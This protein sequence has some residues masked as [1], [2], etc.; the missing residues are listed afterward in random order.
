[1]FDGAQ[2]RLWGMPL[3]FW[4]SGPL[5]A[6]FHL[7]TAVVAT[8]GAMVGSFLNVVIH[9]VPQGKSVVRP[10]SHCPGC[11]AAIPLRLNLPIFSW[12]WLRGRARCC[13]APISPRYIAIEALTAALAVASWLA[14][15]HENPGVAVAWMILWCLL[16][17]ASAVDLEHFMI[18]DRIS[19]GGAVLG[20]FLSAAIPQ[21]HGTA[22][23]SEA[24]ERSALGACVGA[25]LVYGIVRLGKLAFG[26][27]RVDLGPQ[28]R[29][30]F[31]ET[32]IRTPDS[33]LP[34][35]ELFYR[36]S[37]AVVCKA[38]RVELADRC[39]WDAD[40]RLELMREPPR[41]RIG[42]LEMDASEQPWMAVET[43]SVVFPREAMG[44][45]DVKLMAAIGAFLGWQATL[46]ALLGSSLLGSAVG[47]GLILGRRRDWGA[48]LPFG[49]YL[50]VGALVYAF[51]GR[52][53]V[54]RWLALGR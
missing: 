37:D 34:Y 44:L 18:P 16:I 25:G 2:E 50:A 10:G 28:G 3:E 45:G 29:V 11:G 35:E 31:H 13:G 32:G 20:I 40:I 47:V 38:R 22:L 46:F 49:P 52:D 21:L 51:A 24:M 12:L 30:L 4:T 33:D 54:E 6:P 7:W 41:L 15:G 8:A 43:D 53:W 39:Y 14:V 27:F 1:M 23:R 5:G 17:A 48:R 42:D 9:R 26:R 19:L 36:K